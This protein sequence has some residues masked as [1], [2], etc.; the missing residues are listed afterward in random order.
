[1]EKELELFIEQHAEKENV[2]LDGL[3]FSDKYQYDFSENKSVRCMKRAV[4]I[5]KNPPTD[6]PKI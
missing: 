2:S 1:M 4:K 6:A 5:P 3:V